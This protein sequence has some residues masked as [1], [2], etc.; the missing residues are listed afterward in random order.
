MTSKRKAEAARP[1]RSTRAR[2]AAPSAAHAPG[3]DDPCERGPEGIYPLPTVAEVAAR[4]R[5]TDCPLLPPLVAIVSAYA[6]PR[7]LCVLGFCAPDPTR[8]GVG[9]RASPLPAHRRPCPP[10]A[11]LGGWCMSTA[12]EW[13]AAR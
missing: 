12:Q 2:E 1:L 3:A 5:A 8:G 10:S 4:I 7:F 9:T 11:L 13:R 6:D